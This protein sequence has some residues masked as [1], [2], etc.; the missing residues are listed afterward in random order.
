MYMIDVFR[1]IQGEGPY[2]GVPMTFV[3][4]AGC[5]LE[6][7]W[8]DTKYSWRRGDVHTEVYVM[9]LVASCPSPKNVCITGGEPMIQQRDLSKLLN[10]LRRRNY[11]IHIETNGTLPI[12]EDLSAID[13]WVVSPKFG[14][15]QPN[16]ID[17]Y[18]NYATRSNAEM[19]LKF[20]VQHENDVKTVK[21]FMDNNYLKDTVVVIQPERYTFATK[22]DDKQQ[23]LSQMIQLVKW[24]QKHLAKYDYRVLPQL[25]YLLWGDKR[26]V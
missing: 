24:C 13:V 25:H 17:K 10:I 12:T 22:M 26:G 16:I 6:C 5:N 23:Y 15:I 18:L 8:C 21:D 19:Y 20:V 14:Y 11:W 2:I 7:S 4:L 9:L 3:R 1:S